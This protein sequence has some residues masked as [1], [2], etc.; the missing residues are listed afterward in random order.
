MCGIV[1][2]WGNVS[3]QRL[4]TGLRKLAH[5]GPDGEGFFADENHQIYLGHRRLSIL[6]VSAA[7]NQP[8]FYEHLAIVFNGEIYNFVELRNE[9]RQQGFHFATETDT[10]VVM[11]AYLH[12]GVG[13]LERFNGM[14][15]FVIW[16]SKKQEC[17]ISRDRFGKKP[18]F[19]AFYK[20]A[21]LFASEMKAIIPCF[22]EVEV[23]EDFDWCNNNILAYEATDKCLIRYIKRFPAGS[24]AILKKGEQSLRPVRFWETRKE[25]IAVPR[26]YEE[27]VE[28]FRELF[29]DACAIRMRSDVPIG[30]ALSG[31]LDSSAVMCT[32]AHIARNRK[33]ERQATSWQHAFVACF[34]GTALDER[35][36]AEQVVAYLDVPASYLEIAP[37]QSPDK[38]LNYLYFFEELYHTSP[39][40]MIELYS[41]IKKNGVVVSIDGHGADEMM[42]GYRSDITKALLDAGLHPG[43][44]RNILSTYQ[45]M[46]S[47]EAAPDNRPGA[48]FKEWRKQ[49]HIHL[50]GRKNVA[51]HV[52]GAI[53]GSNKKEDIRNGQLGY[54][55]ELLYE[56]FHDTVLPTLLRNYD[57]YSMA[58]GVESR[59]PFMDHRLVSFTFSVPWES[60]LRN[61]YTKSLIRDAVRPFM[62]PDI[63]N[64]KSKIGFNTPILEWL[65]GPW[66]SFIADTIA[67][68]SF[69]NCDLIN[70]SEI[71]RMMDCI[72][73]TD[74][75][76]VAHGEYAWFLLSPYFWQQAVLKQNYQ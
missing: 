29:I 38:L 10:E 12:W 63:V 5:R 51:R 17:F 21:F 54:Y 4:Q 69:R 22:D 59:M 28:Q 56:L 76:D 68:A 44:I 37:T 36:Y 60:K 57:R 41:N 25:L 45:S 8:F 2:G 47:D 11:A 73:H 40:P 7:G 18:L 58:A 34:K 49:M 33:P 42:S 14:W 46:I 6:D 55:N 74:T 1:G 50:N 30:T 72:W 52:L 31:G 20:D 3:Q 48:G 9:L 24:Y 19:Y 13:C 66:R 32:M 65:R 67:S 26:R 27:Q 62:P 39:V 16:D 53:T 23:S 35:V 43:K 71:T 70:H 64:R 15:S 75:Q 61:G